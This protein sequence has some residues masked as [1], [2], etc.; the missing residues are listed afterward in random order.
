MQSKLRLIRQT[1][2]NFKGVRNL[3]FEPNGCDAEV[4]GAN[5]TG[6]TTVLDGFLWLLFDKD[7]AGRKDFAVKTLDGAG[8][9]IPMLEHSV[10]LVLD[11][12]GERVTI[13]KTFC[14]S[15]VKARGAATAT[16]SG[17][18]V[19]Y[20]IDGVPQQ[21][22]EFDAAISRLCEE[23][24]LRLLVDPGYFATKLPWQERRS[25]L[26]ALCGELDDAAVIAS[27]ARLKELSSLLAGRSIEQQRKLLAARKTLLNEE[28]KAIPVRVD[29]VARALPEAPAATAGQLAMQEQQVRAALDKVEAA[30]LAQGGDSQ[31]AGLQ[32]RFEQLQTTLLQK[33]NELETARQLERRRDDVQ[34]RLGEMTAEAAQLAI[35]LEEKRCQWNQLEASV[36]TTP[37]GECCP[38]CG[39]AL[40]VEQLQA[41]RAK[42]QQDF[43]CERRRQQER[44]TADGTALAAKQQQLLTQR[45]T[46]EASLAELEQQLGAAKE[47]PALRQQVEALRLKQQALQ[48][49]LADGQAATQPARQELCRQQEDYRQ[50]LAQIA[51]RRAAVEQQAQGQRRIA[52]LQQREQALAAEYAELER[53]TFLTEEFIRVKVGLLEQRI[54]SRFKLARFRLFEQQVNGALNEVCE[55]LG[56]DGAPYNGGLNNAARI[57]TGIDIINTLGAH[58]GMTAPLFIDNA[59]AVS[60]LID[61]PSQLIR[62]VVSPAEPALQVVLDNA[63]AAVNS[64]LANTPVAAAGPGF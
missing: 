22:K 50:N 15:W 23:G 39:Q 48:Q 42:A 3:C 57:N 1:M 6:K 11:K 8:R 40:P 5:A 59:E 18:R 35:R 25:I 13:R 19:A 28:L 61:T 46:L 32:L 60:E 14:E 21:K 55:V 53:Q 26:L 56:P 10:E 45:Q 38:S 49:Q 64:P 17:H 47:A 16:F 20:E 27:D 62:L 29:E 33:Q 51:C 2:T 54:N 43:D 44:I 34:A 58:Y 37:P 4:R 7:S 63:A 30:L 36:L 12:D 41:A 52:E 9:V 24:L 31:S